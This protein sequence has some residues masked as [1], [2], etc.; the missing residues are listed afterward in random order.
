M[1][2]DFEGE[3]FVALEANHWVSPKTL[4]QIRMPTEVV[5]EIERHPIEIPNDEE[6]DEI[7]HN[8]HPI[9]PS[10]TGYQEEVGPS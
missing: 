3:V 9:G 4:R 10:S 8:A 6:V 2:V 5:A 7:E 1:G